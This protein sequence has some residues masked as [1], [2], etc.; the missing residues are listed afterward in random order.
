MLY[1][2]LIL[3][4]TSCMLHAQDSTEVSRF[5]YKG[6]IK[7]LQT[8]SLYD[9]ADY[10]ISSN[11]FH[12]RFSCS[13]DITENLSLRA[14]MRNRLFWGEM[15]KVNAGFEQSIN[16]RP[17]LMGLSETIFNT[18]GILLHS[19]LDRIAI[20][21]KPQGWNIT[22]GRQRINWGVHT[23][24]N[25]NDIFNTYNL[26]D[27]DYEERP[28]CDALRIQKLY[29]NST[30]EFAMK[31]DT[32]IKSSI[33]ALLFKTNY[34]GYD[35][36]LL[37]GMYKEDYIIGTGWAGNIGEAGFKGECSYFTPIE[38]NVNKKNSVSLSLMLDQTFADNWYCSIGA[39][40]NSTVNLQQSLFT[41]QSN[42]LSPKQI[43]PFETT[44]YVG[45]N[46]QLSPINTIG[47]TVLYSPTNYAL[48]LM[49]LIT[50]NIAE[51]IDID[52]I[53]QSFFAQK[54]D[55]EYSNLA[56]SIFFRSRW[57]F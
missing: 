3:I 49:P 13:Y 33:A 8:V 55:G 24:W 22:F 29:D 7:N 11:M 45:I 16:T 34:E 42:A 30:I 36:Q 2:L 14:D 27:F 53:S 31:P 28:G 15:S 5:S 54:D 4:S 43:F 47:C 20:T 37:A 51:N 26:L 18:S 23:V 10:S 52:F 9:D 32:T 35:I 39:L 19:M 48:I 40:Y 21:Y 12:N 25:P 44:F 38:H 41:L 46:K 17:G 6:Y 1:L 50:Y 57:S 56:T